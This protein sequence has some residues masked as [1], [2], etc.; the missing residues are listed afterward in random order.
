MRE[1]VWIQSER[2]WGVVIYRL[3]EFSLV[4]YEKDG[5]EYETLIEND[6][7]ET[8]EEHAFEYGEE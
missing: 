6:D 4:R 8:W 5:T 3:V 7:L 2:A 1:H